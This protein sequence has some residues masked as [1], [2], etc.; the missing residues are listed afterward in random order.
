MKGRFGVLLT[1][2]ALGTVDACVPEDPVVVSG[3][4]GRSGSGGS[5]PP[6]SCGGSS[7]AALATW[8]NVRDVIEGSTPPPMGCFGADCHTQGDREP[9]LLGLNTAPLSDADLYAKLTTFRTTKCGK[10]VLVRPCAP[11]DSAFY[12]VQANRC[13]A[14]MPQM[15]FGC[16]PEF[17]NCTP[18]DKLEGIRQWIA[19]GAPRP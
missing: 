7:G 5:E 12:L 18:A 16:L 10:R 4:G 15:P 6:L 19:D 8:A 2:A 17:D 13:G 9:I 11:D 14:D 3:T 1:L